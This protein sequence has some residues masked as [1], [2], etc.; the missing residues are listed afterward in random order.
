MRCISTVRRLFV[1]VLAMTGLLAAAGAAHAAPR[2]DAE[3]I[4]VRSAVLGHIC[5]GAFGNVE[6]F[7][8]IS[9]G[10]IPADSTW[11]VSTSRD[12]S[13]YTFKAV[14]DS[15]LIQTSQVGQS[16]VELRALTAIP[17]GT[18]VKVEPRNFYT[19]SVLTISGYGGTDSS[20]PWC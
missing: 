17:N 1:G 7:V 19:D 20:A 14:P 18:V 9:D 2:T 3:A 10:G 16:S 4:G 13:P 15:A 11:R 5:E 12:P 6:K 8:I